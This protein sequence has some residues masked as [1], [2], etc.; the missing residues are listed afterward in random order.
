MHKHFNY[1]NC[2]SLPKQTYIRSEKA[3]LFSYIQTH[4]SDIFKQ[5]IILCLWFTDEITVIVLLFLT[6]ALLASYIMSNSEANL[7]SNAKDKIERC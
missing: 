3:S 7:S 5:G 4:L 1:C 6:V 2:N